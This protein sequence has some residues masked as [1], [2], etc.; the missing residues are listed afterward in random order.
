MAPELPSDAGVDTTC[1]PAVRNVLVNGLAVFNDPADPVLEYVHIPGESTVIGSWIDNETGR[2]EI[3]PL[4]TYDNTSEWAA[5][6]SLAFNVGTVRLNQTWTTR[7]HSQGAQ[8]RG[9]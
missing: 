7:L 1:R 3:L 4:D 2:H 5:G 9:T 8:G 6:Q